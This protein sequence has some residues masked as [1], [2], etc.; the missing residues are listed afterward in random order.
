ML[1]VVGEPGMQLGGATT[2]APF[3]NVNH[4]DT[5]SYRMAKVPRYFR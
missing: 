3:V 5:Y 2:L 4:V 1:S